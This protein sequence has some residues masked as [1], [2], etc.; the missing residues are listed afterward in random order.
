MRVSDLGRR[1]AEL[2]RELD[3][4]RSVEA[5]Q[6]HVVAAA[7]DLVE[8]CTSA[9]LVPSA[10]AEGQANHATPVTPAAPVPSAVTD[11]RLQALDDLQRALR[12][13]PCVDVVGE[14]ALVHSY[15]LAAESRWPRWSAEVV[16]TLGARSLL[17]VRLRTNRDQIGVLTLYSDAVGGFDH[18]ERESAQAIAAHGAVALAAVRNVDRMLEAM[19]RRTT[20]G[21]AIGIVMERF[22]LEEAVAF[23][24]LRRLSQE[25]NRKLFDIAEELVR[26]R[27]VEGL[28]APAPAAD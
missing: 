24:V 13:G 12:E 2:A 28:G 11:P 6:E 8:S 16:R 3:S 14:V 1:M 18:E 15:D 21:A 23:E 4:L 7:V 22:D 26:E 10:P 19:N 20:I 9:S 27:H 17:S 5:V 25:Q